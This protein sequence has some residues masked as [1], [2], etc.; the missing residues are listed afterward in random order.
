MP[1]RKDPV[2]E[3]SHVVVYAVFYLAPLFLGFG[4]LMVYTLG[5][6]PGATLANLAAALFANWLAL[7][8]FAGCELTAIGL[9]WNRAS[10]DNFALGLLGGIGAASLA[11]APAVAV[12][13]A[14]FVQSAGE[15]PTLGAPIFL[16]VFLLV[17][18]AAEEILFRG[19]G[20]QTLLPAL[21]NWIS[22]GICAVL[23]GMLHLG[24]P[25]VTAF[26]I[27]NTVGFGAIFG[28]AFLRSRDLW[29]PIGLHFGWNFTLPLFGERVSGLN[30]K[31]TG[32]EMSWTAGALW[33]GGAY[34]PE[35][36]LLATV[37]LGALFLYVQKAPVRRQASALTDP[38]T[39]TVVCEP[40][41]SS[42]S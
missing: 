17:G 29:L 36:S 25:N 16:A 33:S 6:L 1:S 2:R 7:K 10:S 4:S 21:G 26:G 24:N 19:F 11:L 37:V 8:I 18:S 31:V 15:R 9:R 34:G 39:E 13:A 3:I 22:V 27:A 38:A 5:P 35:A 32:Y 12:G 14:H 40:P 30:M 42:L 23:F 28:Y 20:F 41:S